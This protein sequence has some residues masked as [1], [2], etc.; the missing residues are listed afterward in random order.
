MKMNYVIIITLLLQISNSFSQEIYWESKIQPDTVDYGFGKLLLKSE[1]GNLYMCSQISDGIGFVYPYLLKFSP[2]GNILLKKSFR[3]D[4]HPQYPYYLDFYDNKSIKLTSIFIKYWHDTYYLGA[5]PRF[6]VFN[7]N[8]LTT[9]NIIDT[10][11]TQSL[12]YYNKGVLVKDDNFL[13]HIIEETGDSLMFKKYNND[14][15]FIEEFT[16]GFNFSS[17]GLYIDKAIK[18]ADNGFLLVGALQNEEYRELSLFLIKLNQEY[19]IEWERRLEKSSYFDDKKV[20][21]TIDDIKETDKLD[22]VIAGKYFDSKNSPTVDKPIYLRKLNPKGDFLWEKTY[23]K[24]SKDAITKL[25]IYNNDN[26]FLIGSKY[27]SQEE[28]VKSEF[29]ILNVDKNGNLILDKSWS[30]DSG[31]GFLYDCVF[32]ND[33]VIYVTGSS[34]AKLYIAKLNIHR[35]T[36]IQDAY[37]IRLT[38]IHPNPATSQITL[39]LVDNLISEPE[40]HIIDYLGGSQKVEYQINSSEITINTST[41]SP[42]VYFLRIR[43]REMVEVRKFVVL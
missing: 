17:Y 7:S 42:G 5:F 30:P 14:G 41:L 36:S 20:S 43:S 31:H 2:D 10:S 16:L 33:S 19:K 12:Q 32:E 35:T 21:F 28:K 6:T 22:I 25:I 37:N 1:D 15:Y 24:N 4:S 39:S 27:I 9:S 3:A 8:G 23:G 38:F 29:Y 11:S 18:T 40:I 34:N 13:Y 26:Y